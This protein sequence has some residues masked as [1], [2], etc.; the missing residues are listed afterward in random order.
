M[1]AANSL[2]IFQQPAN[3]LLGLSD[4]KAK[5]LIVVGDDED[6]LNVMENPHS[7]TPRF[8]SLKRLDTPE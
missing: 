6:E 1:K 8:Y 3:S 7:T 2:P 5:V 4:G